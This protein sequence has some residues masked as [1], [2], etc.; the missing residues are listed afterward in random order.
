MDVLL[1]ECVIGFGVP[2]TE[3]SF[4]KQEQSPTGGDFIHSQG[5][6]WDTYRYFFADACAQVLVRLR[7]WNVHV[8]EELTFDALADVFSKPPKVVILFAHWTAREA[9][10]L[11]DG[12]IFS[13]AI[14]RVIPSNFQGI[15]D[16]CVCHPMS[17]VVGIKEKCPDCLVKYTAK[18]A[19]LLWWL[20]L[21]EAMFKILTTRPDYFQALADAFTILSKTGNHETIK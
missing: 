2:L 3:T 18:N 15:F 16:L 13:E 1:N 19:T 6:T 20:Y 12:M 8:I 17:L 11:A 10:E 4:R 14:I 5:L 9:V 7:Q 21:Y